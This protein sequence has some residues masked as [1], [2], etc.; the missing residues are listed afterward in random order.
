MIYKITIR[1]PAQ[2]Q[3]SKLDPQLRE[4]VTRAIFSLAENPRPEGCK[5]LVGRDVW[6]IR[7]GEIRII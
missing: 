4:R 1:K 6:R 5:R 2:K 3:L 7:V